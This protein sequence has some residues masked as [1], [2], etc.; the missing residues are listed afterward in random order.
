M[1][2]FPVNTKSVKIF[3]TAFFII[4]GFSFSA[5]KLLPTSPLLP[6]T[7]ISFQI[8]VIIS[9]CFLWKK[10]GK[11]RS[12]FIAGVVIAISAVL[13]VHT[14]D[15]PFPLNIIMIHVFFLLILFPFLPALLGL[16]ALTYSYFEKFTETAPDTKCSFEFFTQPSQKTK[17]KKHI[18]QAIAIL[19]FSVIALPLYFILHSGRKDIIQ[20]D[21]R[22][23]GK[24]LSF[25]TPLAYE[26][27]C[28]K[29]GN[30]GISKKINRELEC[31]EEVNG[32]GSSGYKDGV[33]KIEYVPKDTI[34]TIKQVYK[35]VQYGFHIDP[36]PGYEIAVLEDA[37][38]KQSVT[39]LNNIEN[40]LQGNPSD[41]CQKEPL[42]GTIHLFEFLEQ[43]KTAKVFFSLSGYT[44]NIPLSYFALV[45]KF[46][47]ANFYNHSVRNIEFAVDPIAHTKGVSAYVDADTLT[48]L[49]ASGYDIVYHYGIDPSY[50]SAISTEERDEIITYLKGREVY[51]D[52]FPQNLKTTPK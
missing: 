48:F 16:M 4:F 28:E 50:L 38:K 10:W 41:F 31:V 30:T 40:F 35:V 2:T 11:E 13:F 20:D 33:K 39:S 5:Y 12:V 49:M 8:L 15:I 44:R 43:E 24:T 29:C 51:P 25:H 36:H 3:L 9:T 21:H 47:E 34:F 45:A 32:V 7:L 17:R 26:G 1:N 19:G 27:D 37:H 18:A 46:R 6:T 42:L 23:I 14:I 52:V 22:Y